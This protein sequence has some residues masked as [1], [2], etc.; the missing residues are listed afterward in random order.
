MADDTGLT[1]GN[2]GME[3]GVHPLAEYLTNLDALIR[4]LVIERERLMDISADLSKPA[5]VRDKAAEEAAV[6]DSRINLLTAQRNAFIVGLVTATAGPSQALVDESKKIATKLAAVI[7]DANRPAAL[8]K[9]A[10]D[11]LT[12]ASQVLSGNVPAAAPA[13]APSPAEPAASPGP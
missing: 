2:G 3:V 10:N 13:P 8:L 4:A 5:S 7:V 9:I 11:F 1:A 12:A 6:L